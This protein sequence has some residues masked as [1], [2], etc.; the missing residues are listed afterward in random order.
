MRY[1]L[2]SRALAYVSCISTMSL[3]MTSMAIAA[4]NVGRGS[5]PCTPNACVAGI[6][7]SK[8]GQF[9]ALASTAHVDA[10]A[11]QLWSAKV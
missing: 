7:V 4:I 6:M 5:S 11:A 1:E 9:G 2:V 10:L 3:F 8:S